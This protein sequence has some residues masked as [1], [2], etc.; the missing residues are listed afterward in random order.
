MIPFIKTMNQIDRFR[1]Y[2]QSLNVLDINL[3][4]LIYISAKARDSHSAAN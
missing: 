1:S 3:I 2:F 4:N